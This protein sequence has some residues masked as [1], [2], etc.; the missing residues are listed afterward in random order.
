MVKRI[1]FLG[2]I[3]VAAVLLSA[4]PA[5]AQGGSAYHTVFYSDSSH[6]TQVGY[7]IGRAHV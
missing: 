1:K 2:S 3:A 4:G 5:S 7:Q 6:T